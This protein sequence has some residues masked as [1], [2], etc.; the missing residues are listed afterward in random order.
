LKFTFVGGASTVTGSCFYLEVNDLK[1][2]V[3]CGMHQGRGAEEINLKPFPFDP[4][5]ID[6]IFLTH[7]HIDHSGMLP[8]AVKEGFKGKVFTTPATR[9]LLEPLL[10]DSANI[11]ESDAEWL[12]KMNMRAGKPPVEP[13]YTAADVESLLPLFDLKPY[14][15]IFHLGSG[16]KYRFIDA[17]HIL[18]SAS[19]ELWYQ[20]SE[21]EKKI[22]FSGDIGKIDNPIIRDPER[23]PGDADYIVIESTYG[24]REH[25]PMKETIDEFVG[26]IKETFSKGGNVY[27]PSFAVGRTQ[28]L[29]Y[30]LNN[31]VRE[32]RLYRID[33][34]LDSPLAEK[35]TGVYI[36]H[37]EL[38]DE[39]ARRLFTTKASGTAIRLHFVRTVEESMKLNRLKSGNIIIAGSG[40]C[41]GGR[42]RHHLKHNLWRAEC[43]IV[44]VGYQ[45]QGT[46]GRKIVSGA[47]SVNILGSEVAVR[48]AIHTINGFSAHAGQTGLLNWLSNFNNS[49]EVFVVHGEE[50]SA[51]TLIEKIKQ[52]YGFKT[53]RP[54]DG[55]TVQI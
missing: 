55:D 23:P 6:Y 15:K 54:A 3:E 21:E 11:Q 19:L 50:S 49:P 43:G 52:R 29:I 45:A 12:T 32:G 47:K 42:I 39:E 25:K 35:A 41:T 44:F 53:L 36:K 5:T 28:D 37:R 9:D 40:M 20:D 2:L 27:I 22:V 51:A 13:L 46:L 38:Y 4:S 33:V 14:D 8:R 7:A 10:L 18:G 1:L 30:I 16:I 34:Y 31:L 24:N 48:A 17:G 26:A